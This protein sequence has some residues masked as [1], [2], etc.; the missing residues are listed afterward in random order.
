MFPH[1]ALL[2]VSCVPL[3]SASR[4]GVTEDRATCR[5][6]PSS[7]GAHWLPRRTRLLMS[8]P[9]SP[10]SEDELLFCSPPRP[11]P[12]FLPQPCRA[13]PGCP[14]PSADRGCDK[15]CPRPRSKGASALNT[16]GKG[17]PEQTQPRSP[18][19][20]RPRVRRGFSLAGARGAP[21]QAERPRRG[22]PGERTSAPVPAG[23]RPPRRITR[24]GTSRWRRR[25]P[26]DEAP[27]AGAA[28]PSASWS[29]GRFKHESVRSRA[30][31]GGSA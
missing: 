24:R 10:F 18:A 30:G 13:A 14:D 12:P 25:A 26:G 19:N 2:P 29:R 7:G 4:G 20:R 9:L 27:C 17:L 23:Q 16:K 31:H 1:T 6:G 11:P 28:G 15:S 3:P 8:L 22:V 5:P 21:F